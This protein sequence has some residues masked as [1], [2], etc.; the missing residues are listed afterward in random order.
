M[1]AL[2]LVHAISVNFYRKYL[3]IQ[4]WDSCHP[5][6]LGLLFLGVKVTI[7]SNFKFSCCCFENHQMSTGLYILTR[8]KK[9]VE[10]LFENHSEAQG[11]GEYSEIM[12]SS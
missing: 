2:V 1:L 3:S 10:I 4:P 5:W 12:E 8:K 11:S 6:Y 7:Y 9:T